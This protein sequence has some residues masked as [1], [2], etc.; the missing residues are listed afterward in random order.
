MSKLPWWYWLV[1][2]VPGLVCVA[3]AVQFLST[4]VPIREG[5]THAIGVEQL[6]MAF[7]LYVAFV[8]LGYLL[9]VLCRPARRPVQSTQA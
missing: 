1:T 5:G 3:L 7:S 6:I 9:L 2:L 8:L 4:H